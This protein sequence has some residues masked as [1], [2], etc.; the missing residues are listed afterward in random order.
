MGTEDWAAQGRRRR[1]FCAQII[2]RDK[3]IPGYICPRC[4]QP[5]DWNLI[6][7]HLRSASVDHITERQDGG[8]LF[9]P[10]NAWTM[11]LECNSSKGAKRAA[12]RRR[13]QGTIIVELGSV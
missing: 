7:P 9:D 10:D 3:D 6:H 4:G 2:A 1:T 13:E 12:Q 8:A 5:I 11:H